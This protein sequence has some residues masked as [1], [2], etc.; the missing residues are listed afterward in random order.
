[1]SF[2]VDSKFFQFVGSIVIAYIRTLGT[3]I[4]TKALKYVM[5]SLSGWLDIIYLLYEALCD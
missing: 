1:M 2:G 4:P 3:D 5:E